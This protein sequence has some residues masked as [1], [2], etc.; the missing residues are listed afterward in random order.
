MATDRRSGTPRLRPELVALLLPG[1]PLR[2]RDLAELTGFS[3][4]FIQVEITEG[5]LRAARPPVRHERAGQWLISREE[6]VRYLR[7]IGVSLEG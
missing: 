5:R 6:A 3:L 1:P 2:T 7:A 4:R